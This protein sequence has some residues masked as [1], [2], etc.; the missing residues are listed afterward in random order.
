M[1][2]YA[3]LSGKPSNNREELVRMQQFYAK[4]L[5]KAEQKIMLQNA[6]I[7]RLSFSG[8]STSTTSPQPQQDAKDGAPVSSEDKTL[9]SPSNE[10][11]R[12]ATHEERIAAL[13]VLDCFMKRFCFS[14]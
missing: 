11:A 3:H 8:G 4:K 1:Y 7:R 14:A 10:A 6:K 13:E 12:Q 5:R 9:L 2:V